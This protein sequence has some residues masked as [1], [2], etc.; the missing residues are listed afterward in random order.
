[1]AL[2]FD[3]I[4]LFGDSITQGAYEPECGFAFGAAMQHAYARKMDVV[5][6]GFGGY[7]S[8]HAAAIIPYLLK[9]E[10]SI[11]LM[12]VFFGTNDSIV[13]ESKNHVPIPR[14]KDNIRKIVLSAQGA[15]AKVLLIGPGPFDHHGFVAVMEEGWVCDRTTLRARMYCD[16][17]VELGS[18]LGVPV[19]PLWDLIM[20]DLGWKEGYDVYG[21]A[22]VPDV[23]SFDGYFYDGLHFL[24]KAYRIMFGNV[25]KS[26]K[27]SYPELQPDSIKEKLPPCDDQM[28][29]DSLKEAVAE[30]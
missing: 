16:A 28:T 9:Q 21:L 6:R 11:K 10:S 4:V 8:D 25:I 13:P 23:G 5:Q 29:L 17:A 18:E 26:I 27:E 7:N 2:G 14:F 12:I 24:G 30:E 1:M 3:K 19:V 15:G 22:E 20:A